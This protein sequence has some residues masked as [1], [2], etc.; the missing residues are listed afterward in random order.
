MNKTILLVAGV[1]LAGTVGAV[2]MAEPAQARQRLARCVVE[3]S[4]TIAYRGPCLFQADR[5]G[6]FTIDPP[7]GRRF[8]GD[9]TSISLTVTGRGVG[10]VRGLTTDGVNSRWGRAARSSRNAACWIGADFRVCA[11]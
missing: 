8:G 4:Q 3:T 1:G 6:S 11:Y 2:G 10:Q 7:R 5:G 9:I